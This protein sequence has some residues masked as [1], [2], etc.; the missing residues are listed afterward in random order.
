MTTTR[1]ADKAITDQRAAL[2]DLRDDLES[3]EAEVISHTAKT[4][5][6]RGDLARET[7]RAAR[8]QECLAEVRRVLTVLKEAGRART[9]FVQP[10][11]GLTIPAR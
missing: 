8:D 9:S 6:S 2:V 4:G 10:C 11:Y 7:G 3:K 5:V 1:A